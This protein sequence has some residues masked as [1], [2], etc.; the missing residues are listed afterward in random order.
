MPECHSVLVYTCGSLGLDVAPVGIWAVSMN[1]NA[2]ATSF[3]RRQGSRIKC[4][5]TVTVGKKR[6]INSLEITGA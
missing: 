2:V 6:K 5:C 1:S 4:P 3:L